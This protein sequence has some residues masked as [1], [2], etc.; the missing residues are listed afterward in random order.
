MKCPECQF[1]NREGAKF[2]KKCGT[3]LEL[4]CPQCKNLLSTEEILISLSATLNQV[5]KEYF[6]I[7]F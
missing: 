7:N 3:K 1:E 6:S 5:M 2:C 4:T